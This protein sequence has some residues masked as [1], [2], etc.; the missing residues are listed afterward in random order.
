MDGLPRLIRLFPVRDLIRVGMSYTMEAYAF[1]NVS[2]VSPQ[3]GPV[4]HVMV[5]GL[6]NDTD[7]AC[8]LSVPMH[9]LQSVLLGPVQRV[10]VATVSPL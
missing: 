9:I 5:R 4:S 10:C 6:V 1:P 7:A 8:A 3:E 2:V